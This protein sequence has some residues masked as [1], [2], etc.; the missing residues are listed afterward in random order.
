MPD[1]WNYKTLSVNV[2]NGHVHDTTLDEQLTELGNQGWELLAVTPL[3]I[4]G[5]TASL[6]HHLR[7]NE[8]RTRKVGFQP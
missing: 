4:E 6:L 8:E 5:K 3:N 2:M 7:R 1:G